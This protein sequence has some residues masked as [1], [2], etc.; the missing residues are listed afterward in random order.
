MLFFILCY[1]P[2]YLSSNSFLWCTRKM[3][4]PVDKSVH[5]T[6]QKEI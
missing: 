6:W 2:M 3:S 1:I 4:C 5:K